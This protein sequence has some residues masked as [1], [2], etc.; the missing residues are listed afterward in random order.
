MLHD[1][2]SK[3]IIAACLILDLLFLMKPRRIL[4]SA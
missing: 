3:A 4:Y 2:P 1:W